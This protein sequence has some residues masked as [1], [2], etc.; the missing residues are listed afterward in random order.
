MSPKT[1]KVKS[2][3]PDDATAAV[4]RQRVAT[5]R[6]T[7]RVIDHVTAGRLY[8][9]ATT[10][11]LELYASGAVWTRTVDTE[12]EFTEGTHLGHVERWS[13]YGLDAGLDREWD[14]L[15]REWVRLHDAAEYER[16]ERRA[17][18]ESERGRG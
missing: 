9:V 1:N 13:Y 17:E 15:L 10:A 12:D 3:A 14:T 6:A 5:R 18:F 11:R 16:A 7:Q 8:P 2:A 4:R